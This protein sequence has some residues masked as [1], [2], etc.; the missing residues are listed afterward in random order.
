MFT[1]RLIQFI[2]IYTHFSVC[3]FPRTRWTLSFYTFSSMHI[4][5]WSHV[6]SKGWWGGS[7]LQERGKVGELL[8]P[9]MVRKVFL[10]LLLYSTY[11]STFQ[12]P[13]QCPQVSS[14]VA[15]LNFLLFLWFRVGFE[16]GEARLIQAST[17]THIG[18]QFGL[19]RMAGWS[20]GQEVFHTSERSRAAQSY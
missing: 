11:L 19:G 13:S 14:P 2:S 10:F 5:R 20:T 3:F 9:S 1:A 6:K 16:I 7:G 17:F 15:P 12:H 8:E 4:I 18:V